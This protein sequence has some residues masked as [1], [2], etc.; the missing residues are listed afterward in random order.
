MNDWRS[1][2]HIA[3]VYER[4][5]AP[6]MAMPARDLVALAAPPRAGRVLDV[7]TGTGV[8]AQAAR[9]AVGP[10]GVVVGADVSLG[11]LSVAARARPGVRLVAAEAI[12]LPFGDGSFDAV[13]AN[14]VISHFTK[15]ET[16]LFDMVRVLRP[17]GRLAVSAWGPAQ[18]EF[19]RTWRELVGA[20]VGARMLADLFR[21]VVPWEEHFSDRDR[22]Q[23]ALQEAGLRPV[24][25]EVREYRFLTSRD[26]YL[27]GREAS[28]SGRFLREMLG[29]RGFQSFL[30]RARKAFAERFPETI[31]DF[32]DVLLAVGTK[33]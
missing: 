4:I 1:Y 8:A 2:D 3:E 23:E 17:G 28:A 15:Y 20:V 22:L 30:E 6:H 21:Q 10:E 16:A 7:G 5:H 31:N 24:R 9:E 13:T 33:P 18:D 11:M 19:Q 12:D 27:A 14:F 29:A 25:I 32:R 26:D